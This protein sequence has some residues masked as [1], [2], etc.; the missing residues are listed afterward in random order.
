MPKKSKYNFQERKNKV[1]GHAYRECKTY[2][3]T[4][5]NFAA[6][7]EKYITGTA[8]TPD[9]CWYGNEIYSSDRIADVWGK[10]GQWSRW[11]LGN[12]LSTGKSEPYYTLNNKISC[13]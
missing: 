13:K 8:E 5:S 10:K 6:G 4:T 12:Y 3:K 9:T 7:L 1:V 2:P 11:W